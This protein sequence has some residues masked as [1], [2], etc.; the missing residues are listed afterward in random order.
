MTQCTELWVD[1]QEIRTTKIVEHDLPA[2]KEGQVL[3]AIDKFGL[4]AN[5]VSYAVTGDSVGYWG[6]Y[7]AEDQWGKVPVWGCANII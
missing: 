7:P 4:T 1:K 5:N 3:A 2:L 6:F